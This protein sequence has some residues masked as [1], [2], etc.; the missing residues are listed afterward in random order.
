MFK[1]ASSKYCLVTVCINMFDRNVQ[2]LMECSTPL[3]K[4]EIRLIV[5]NNSRVNYILK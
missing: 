5:T 1:I 4:N 2:R 3:A